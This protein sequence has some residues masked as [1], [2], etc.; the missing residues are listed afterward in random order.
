MLIKI[1]VGK[2]YRNIELGILQKVVFVGRTY[3]V[4]INLK[5]NSEEISLVNFTQN[6]WEEV[7]EWRIVYKDELG[8]ITV[9]TTPFKSDSE[10]RNS[11]FWK[12]NVEAF[13][14]IRVDA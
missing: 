12:D 5:T 11:K 13:K 14:T 1:E 3:I 7:E 8:D 6:F 4:F 10:A 9:G 2:T